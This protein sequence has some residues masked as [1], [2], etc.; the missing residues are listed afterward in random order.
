M[1]PTVGR[2]VHI[3]NA[4]N[5]VPAIVTGITLDQEGFYVT[6]FAPNNPA[7]HIKQG[8]GGLLSGGQGWVRYDEEG[9]YWCWPPRD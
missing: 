3:N 4:G 1:N 8:T 5:W 6:W 2:I 9:V 7:Y